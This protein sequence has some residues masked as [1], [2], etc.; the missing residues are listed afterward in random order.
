MFNDAEKHGQSMNNFVNYYVNCLLHFNL[1]SVREL[2]NIFYFEKKKEIGLI[3]D[4]KIG[5]PE[6]VKT[7]FSK[8]NLASTQ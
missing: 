2:G 4:G 8:V 6:G 1:H 3:E 7:N 5:A